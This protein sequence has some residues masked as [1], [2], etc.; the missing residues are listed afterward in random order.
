MSTGNA[1]DFA[2]P[3]ALTIGGSDPSGGA[4]I[5]ADLKTFAAYD[6][7]GASVI[8][9]VTAQNTRG[10]QG[11]QT[12]GPDF[13]EAQIDSVLSDLNVHAMKLGALLDP[14]V[15]RAVANGLERWPER[16]LVVDP[17]MMSKHGHRLISEEGVEVL[18][19]ELV[20]KAVL[21]T[22]NRHEARLF[23][24][25][26]DAT[27]D[28]NTKFLAEKLADSVQ[29]SVLVTGGASDGDEIVDWLVTPSATYRLSHPRVAGSHQH[30]AGCTL[31]AAIT[32]QMAHIHQNSREPIAP[33]DVKSC[34]VRAREWVRK[35]MLH[36]PHI[37]SGEGPVWHGTSVRGFRSTK[38]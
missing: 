13:I 34:V 31:S 10:V 26:D 22:P 35:A 11:V 24:G 28:E 36:A 9:L 16:P 6:T 1:S 23:V 7:Y 37:G 5:Q 14:Q 4:G 20:P 33:L 17:V 12:I 15:I 38:N 25:W 30:G 32:A 2:P 3:I 29:T 27:D 19:S 8:T 18:R 21:L